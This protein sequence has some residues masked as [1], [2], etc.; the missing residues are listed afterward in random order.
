LQGLKLNIVYEELV[1]NY[2]NLKVHKGGKGS[3][4]IGNVRDMEV[5]ISGSPPLL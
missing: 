1:E 5:M 2:R 4:I 3:V